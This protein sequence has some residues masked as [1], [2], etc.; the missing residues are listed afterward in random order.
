MAG[1][2]LSATAVLERGTW[3][4]SDKETEAQSPPPKLQ[5]LQ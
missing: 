4:R 1:L 2:S 3:G 5:A